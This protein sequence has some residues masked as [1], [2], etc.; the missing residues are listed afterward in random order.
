[1]VVLGT[2]IDGH[3]YYVVLRQCFEAAHLVTASTEIYLQATRSVLAHNDCCRWLECRLYSAKVSQ[4]RSDRHQPIGR[5]QGSDRSHMGRSIL[6]VLLA[7]ILAISHV[8]NNPTPSAWQ[9]LF[10]IFAPRRRCCLAAVSKEEGAG[11]TLESTRAALSC[12][13]AASWLSLRWGTNWIQT[14]AAWRR[15][16]H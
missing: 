2:R 16:E 3:S 7:T 12:S 10:I 8:T 14:V 15:Y 5:H 9:S 6:A 11:R 1:M 4:T 13:I